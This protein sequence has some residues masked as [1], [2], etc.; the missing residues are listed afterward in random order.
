[1]RGRKRE[2]ERDMERDRERER[3]FKV[4]KKNVSTAMS[5]LLESLKKVV[6]VPKDSFL[7]CRLNADI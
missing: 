2:K 4:L 6:F 5:L 1:M 7:S 3:S